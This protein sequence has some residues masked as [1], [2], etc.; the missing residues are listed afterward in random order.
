MFYS[1]TLFLRSVVH[2]FEK[3]KK[4]KKRRK[5]IKPKWNAQTSFNYFV[6]SPLFLLFSF[7]DSLENWPL[8]FEGRKD[9]RKK[10]KRQDSNNSKFF[11]FTRHP[12]RGNTLE[13][14]SAAVGAAAAVVRLPKTALRHQRLW[15]PAKEKL[16][17]WKQ[18]RRKCKEAGKK[19]RLQAS[20]GE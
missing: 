9:K 18:E 16:K 8:K 15:S 10:S 7:K 5:Q 12:A 4:Q 2:F 17:N 6:Q 13:N 20:I 19:N 11:S 1:M 14:T 3:R